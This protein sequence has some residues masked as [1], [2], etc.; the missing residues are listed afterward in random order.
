MPSA[1]TLAKRALVRL[2]LSL[3]TAYRVRVYVNRESE[4]K[5]VLTAY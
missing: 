1:T 4:D 5:V 2:L 3:A